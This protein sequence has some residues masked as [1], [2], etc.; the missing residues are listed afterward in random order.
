MGVVEHH[1]HRTGCDRLGEDR[2]DL[3]SDLR[4]RR[5]L[6]RGAPL[7]SLDEG[8]DPRE[9][10]EL[11][12]PGAKHVQ[13]GEIGAPGVGLSAA[14]L[15]DCSARRAASRVL[16][17][18]ARLPD[19]GLAPKLDEADPPPG[20]GHLLEPLKLAL[21]PDEASEPASRSAAKRS[22]CVPGPSSSNTRTGS[23]RPRIRC[24]PSAAKLKKSRQRRA[25]SSPTRI[26]PGDADSS[27]RAAI[28]TVDPSAV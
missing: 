21:P 20:P 16:E 7:Q 15:E 17:H 26:C 6:L 27:S 23:A 12:R 10:R 2:S 13:P 11:R 5:S 19:S 22:W 14:G 1:Q 28:P 18:Q 4:A 24:S 3:G 9:V 8:V 25:V